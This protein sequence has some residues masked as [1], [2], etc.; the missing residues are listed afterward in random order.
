MLLDDLAPARAQDDMRIALRPVAR[1]W[2][3]RQALPPGHDWNLIL[4]PA[5]GH[6]RLQGR[7]LRGEATAALRPALAAR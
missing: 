6:W 3:A 4:A 5:D 1:G 2:M 7:L